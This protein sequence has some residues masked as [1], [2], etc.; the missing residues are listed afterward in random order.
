MRFQ[1][2]RSGA[3][4]SLVVNGQ[5]GGGNYSEGIA[6]MGRDGPG[7][8]FMCGISEWVLGVCL[9]GWVMQGTSSAAGGEG[10]YE[11]P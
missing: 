6:R 7:E 5:E 10:G 4:I 11:D 3:R 2:G 9:V 1:S 8:G